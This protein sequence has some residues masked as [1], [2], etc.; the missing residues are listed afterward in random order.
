MKKCKKCET[1]MGDEYIKCPSCG[2]KR[3][4]LTAFSSSI[5][6]ARIEL[7]EIEKDEP[8]SPFVECGTIDYKEIV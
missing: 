1:I 7:D 6:K 3:K 4:E 5:Q 2:A 8:T